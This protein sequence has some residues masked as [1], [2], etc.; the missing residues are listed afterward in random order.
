M[1]TCQTTRNNNRGR[2]VGVMVWNRIGRCKIRSI[3]RA[4]WHESS[5]PSLEGPF[6]FI[7]SP[8]NLNFPTAITWRTLC[9]IRK[10]MVWPAQGPL[11]SAPWDWGVRQQANRLFRRCGIHTARVTKDTKYNAAME[12]NPLKPYGLPLENDGTV[13]VLSFHSSN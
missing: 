2:S 5:V 6:S 8:L 9:S 13:F 12:E 10:H 3:A 11:S 4:G 1:Y 7:A